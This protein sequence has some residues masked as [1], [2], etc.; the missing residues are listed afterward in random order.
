[1]DCNTDEGILKIVKLNKSDEDKDK[2]E[3]QITQFDTKYLCQFTSITTDVAYEITQSV[4]QIHDLF[5]FDESIF[6]NVIKTQ[7]AIAFRNDKVNLSWKVDI[8]DKEYII[9][10]ILDK[11][12][13]EDKDS[14]VVQLQIKNKCLERRIDELENKL[15]E[16]SENFETIDKTIDDKFNSLHEA[17]NDKLSIDD[18]YNYKIKMNLTRFEIE[19][20]V[21]PMNN[22][23]RI[24]F[25]K[26][27]SDTGY[28]FNKTGPMGHTIFASIWDIYNKHNYVVIVKY[29]LDQ[30]FR[31]NRT[32]M[33][34]IDAYCNSNNYKSE[35]NLLL[36][37]INSYM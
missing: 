17:L 7:P 12:V 1:M 4:R 26:K 18:F 22:L 29:L 32:D 11:K 23:S 2:D 9:Q 33:E 15:K 30:G 5:K 20:I 31:P 28:D 6:D 24:K 21:R 37:L 16:L 36:K 13:H 3:T 8:M 25:L 34:N 14:E 19:I 10:V 35:G 27:L